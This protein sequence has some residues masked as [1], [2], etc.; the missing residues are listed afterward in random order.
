[1]SEQVL[2]FT[3]RPQIMELIQKD[4]PSFTKDSYIPAE[5]LDW[6]KLQYTKEAIGNEKLA[7]AIRSHEII[8]DDLNLCLEEG[9][10]NFIDKIANFASSY[11]FGICL[12]ILII[13]WV[14]FN[15]KGGF[16]N[17]PFNLLDLVLGVIASV[18]ALFIMISQNKSAKQDKLRTVNALKLSLK[19][20]FELNVI[21]E[22]IDHIKDV[23]MPEIYKA[24]KKS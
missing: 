15:K 5:L 16:D 2:G 20:E 10:P 9:K 22:K 24:V 13:S 14:V 18:Q 11:W 7:K 8:S 19:N 23:Q 1:M 4:V 6:Y 12:I 21:R 3:I 17:Y